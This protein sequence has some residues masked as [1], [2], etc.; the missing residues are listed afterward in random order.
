MESTL[1]TV[2]TDVVLK[3][4]LFY[5]ACG[6]IY[7]FSFLFCSCLYKFIFYFCFVKKEKVY[8]SHKRVRGAI[9]NNKLSCY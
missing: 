2:N 4:L 5:F 6:C 1:N 8:V 7:K 9:F 3:V